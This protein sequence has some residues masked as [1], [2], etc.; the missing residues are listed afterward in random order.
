MILTNSSIGSRAVTR[1]R[2]DSPWLYRHSHRDAKGTETACVA[3]RSRLNF[4]QKARTSLLTTVT[5]SITGYVVPGCSRLG[6]RYE[7]G[8]EKVIFNIYRIQDLNITW[9]PESHYYFIYLHCFTEREGLKAKARNHAV[10]TLQND[11]HCLLQ[12]TSL[13]APNRTRFPSE[14][15]ATVTRDVLCVIPHTIS[16]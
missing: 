16:P 4:Y 6:P 10:I 15:T 2:P 3:I 1:L 14:D 13:Y 7:T 12:N 5:G 8:N 11:T 9:R